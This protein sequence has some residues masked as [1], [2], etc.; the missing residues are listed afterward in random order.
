MSTL[1][2]GWSCF[3]QHTS[4]GL[5][6]SRFQCA[7]A[8]FERGLPL[9]LSREKKRELVVATRFSGRRGPAPVGASARLAF[10]VPLSSCVSVMKSSRP[11]RAIPIDESRIPALFKPQ[12]N[13]PDEPAFDP[14]DVTGILEAQPIDGLSGFLSLRRFEAIRCSRSRRGAWMRRILSSI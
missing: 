1:R 5:H 6:V 2:A 12:R 8:S 13:P 4:P 7:G 3:R 10:F 14:S 11:I 9:P